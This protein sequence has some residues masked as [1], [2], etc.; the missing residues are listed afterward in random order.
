VR[1]GAEGVQI[2]LLLS[3][4]SSLFRFVVGLITHQ[5]INWPDKVLADFTKPG[6]RGSCLGENRWPT[7]KIA[8]L[9]S[10]EASSAA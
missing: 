5:L 10:V 9:R 6:Q 1:R 2:V 4:P 3:A 7:V 8:A